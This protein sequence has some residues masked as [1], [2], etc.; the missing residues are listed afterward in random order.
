MEEL[1]PC[2][3]CGGEAELYEDKGGYSVDREALLAL[4]DE[5]EAGANRDCGTTSSEPA[6]EQMRRI[7]YYAGRIREACGEVG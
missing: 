7:A 6:R 4:A 3:F 5:M 2:P 1:R